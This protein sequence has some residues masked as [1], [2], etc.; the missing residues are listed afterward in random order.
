[1]GDDK[2]ETRAIAFYA[3][4]GCPE[5]DRPQEGKEDLHERVRVSISS[6][7][8]VVNIVLHHTGPPLK[9]KLT[10]QDGREKAA[11]E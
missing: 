11:V 7:P 2:D 9:R 6:H 4:L 10:V 3:G 5:N 1:M 8:R